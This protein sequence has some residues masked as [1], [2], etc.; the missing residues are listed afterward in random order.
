MSSEN[1]D[2]RT[3]ILNAAWKLLE[4]GQGRG[5]RMGDIAKTAGISRQAVYLHFP[6]RA[7]LLV[8]TTRHLDEVKDVD[9]RLQASR[10]ATIG[11]D[12]LAAFVEAWGNYIPEVYGVAKALIAMQ[13]TDAAARHAWADRMQAVREGC[14]ATVK[15]LK[16]DG[17]LVPGHSVKE[18][19]DILWSLLSVQTWEHLTRDCGWSQRR[20]V[21]TMKELAGRML[22]AAPPA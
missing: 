17:V 2:T 18:A 4:A 21:E 6:T 9:A 13:D 8:A 11:T 20:Y 10:T 7:E 15:A 16:G 5:V 19:T 12:R 3:R 1:S 14:A 22:V